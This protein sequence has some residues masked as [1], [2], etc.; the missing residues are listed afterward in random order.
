MKRGV[1]NAGTCISRTR[2]PAHF[3][4]F[5]TAVSRKKAAPAEKPKRTLAERLKRQQADSS[6]PLISSSEEMI[7]RTHVKTSKLLRSLHEAAVPPQYGA[8]GQIIGNPQSGWK[9]EEWK[10][11]WGTDG[12]LFLLLLIG[13]PRNTLS[14]CT[15]RFE[16]TKAPSPW[17]IAKSIVCFQK[18]AFCS[19]QKAGIYPQ[20]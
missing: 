11:D 2:A 17:R 15:E 19:S 16:A 10:D 14:P 6:N 3:A 12:R 18:M 8:D 1:L 5:A 9:P 7:N 20:N 4:G 13:H